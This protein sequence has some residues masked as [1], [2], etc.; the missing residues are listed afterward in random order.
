MF[1]YDQFE[2]LP[3]ILSIGVSPLEIDMLGELDAIVENNEFNYSED[4]S[5]LD[6]LVNSP[7]VYQEKVDWQELDYVVNSVDQIDFVS[8]SEQ[9]ESSSEIESAEELDQL[10]A[11]A[12][13]IPNKSTKWNNNRQEAKASK[14]N[15]VF[16]Q[17]MRVPVKQLDSLNNLIGE[18]VVRRNRLEEDQEKLRQFLDNL[19]GQVQNLSDVSSRMQDLYEKS[20]LEGALMDSS[21]RNQ[22][23][24][25]A[26]LST[27]TTTGKNVDNNSQ[28]ASLVDKNKAPELDELE[29][30]RFTGFHL[31]SQEIIE[32][33]V[34]VREST[35]DIQFLVDETDQLGRN[36]REITTQLQQ[37]INKSRM[38]P[39]AQNADRLPLPIRK[40]PE[41]YQ[42]QVQLK[43]EGREVLIDKMILEHIWDPLLQIS[44]NS[45]T[46]GIELPL[47]KNWTN[48]DIIKNDS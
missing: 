1:F 8:T 4:H 27:T 29:L 10:L 17:S 16:E 35:S 39:F 34:K 22:A 47:L 21:R 19:L 36:L 40:M 24:V 46:H 26:Q 42:K 48:L 23:V 15:R 43:L 25:K 12:V 45:V 41:S 38:V 28:N 13:K 30:D 2:E 33:I 20:L 37:G 44:K 6:K 14:A 5:E 11:Q 31:L 3:K 9:S 18:M 7:G 32:L